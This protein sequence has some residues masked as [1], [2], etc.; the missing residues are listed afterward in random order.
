MGATSFRERHALQLHQQIN[1]DIE[2][3]PFDQDSDHTEA[4]RQ[5]SNIWHP[6]FSSDP[7]NHAARLAEGVLTK[8]IGKQYLE[9]LK[10]S[11]PTQKDDD[12]RRQLQFIRCWHDTSKSVRFL[13]ARAA[14]LPGEVVD[15]ND[16]DLTEAEKT[17]IRIAAQR[18]RD[19]A[20][21]LT[22]I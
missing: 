1:A 7:S 5:V 2:R 8:A 6:S 15:K 20:D 22:K 19:L 3:D 12:A 17:K 18:L 21:S 4:P 14:G 9:Q 11:K 13:I 16:R 10:Q